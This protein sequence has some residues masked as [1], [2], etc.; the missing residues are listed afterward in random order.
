MDVGPLLEYFKPLID[1]L[2]TQNQ[3]QTKGWSPE[4]PTLK[5]P[6]ARQTVTGINAS[7]TILPSLKYLFLA[8]YIALLIC[9]N[10]MVWPKIMIY[11]L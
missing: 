4:C 11:A 3:G 10:Q 8:I 9:T 2:K 6:A 5:K 1:W 7:Q